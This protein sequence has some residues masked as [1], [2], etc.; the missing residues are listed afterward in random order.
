MKQMWDED[1]LK[2]ITRKQ[3]TD[4]EITWFQLSKAVSMFLIIWK[5]AVH[6]LNNLL[7]LQNLFDEIN[8]TF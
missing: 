3:H 1:E 2:E 6:S 7:I 8:P 5:R 4:I